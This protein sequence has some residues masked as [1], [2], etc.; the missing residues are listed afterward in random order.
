[1]IF[2]ALGVNSQML[3]VLAPDCAETDAEIE[4]LA[5]ATGL[6][7]Y[8]LRTRLRPGA[9]GVLKVIAN[10]DQAE[11]LVAQLD[12]IGIRAVII[13]SSVG[14]DHERKVVYLRRL[15][16]LEDGMLLGLSEREMQVPFGALVA[17]V[18]GEVHLGRNIGGDVNSTSDARGPGITDAFAAADLHFATVHWVARIDA[19]ELEF[20]SL[21]S[22]H[23][24]VGE[25]LDVLVD[26]LAQRAHVRVDRHL[27][28]SSLGSHTAA[29]R[30]A[31]LIPKSGPPPSRRGMPVPCDEHFDAYSRL[32]AEAERLYRGH[33]GHPAR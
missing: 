17:I 2:I 14:Q 4:Q 13:D 28:T 22:P 26:W 31:S 25:R 3:V 8:D 9:W 1:M 6:V 16:I 23:S 24:N 11:S 19:R 21:I 10:Q 27:R 12:L 15:E 32:V 33:T 5:Q 18:R 7:A 20:P 29:S 30:G